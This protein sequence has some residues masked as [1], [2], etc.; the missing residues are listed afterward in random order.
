MHRVEIIN[1]P[2]DEISN[3]YGNRT[4]SLKVAGDS[5]G[6]GGG[7]DEG[8]GNQRL[9]LACVLCAATW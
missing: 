9:L 3:L 5:E 2:L 1:R 4:V 6:E 7:G 8:E